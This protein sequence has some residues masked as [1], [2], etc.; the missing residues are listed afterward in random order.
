VGEGYLICR[1]RKGPQ[2]LEDCQD[3]G[4][5]GWVCHELQKGNSARKN[6]T[7]PPILCCMVGTVRTLLREEGTLDRERCTGFQD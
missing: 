3:G 7:E 2:P 6:M 5:E 1:A 4:E